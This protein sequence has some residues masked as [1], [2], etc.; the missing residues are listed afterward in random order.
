MDMQRHWLYKEVLVPD[1]VRQAMSGTGCFLAPLVAGESGQNRQSNTCTAVIVPNGLL[2]TNEQASLCV[3]AH[4]L[5][6][7]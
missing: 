2:E 3:L 5:S 6:Q 1:E 4:A 7:L